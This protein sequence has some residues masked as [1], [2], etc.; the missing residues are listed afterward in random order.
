ML[1][2]GYIP[3]SLAKNNLI[4]SSGLIS[5]P[6]M[7]GETPTLIA[8][9][10]FQSMTTRADNCKLAT[11]GIVQLAVLQRGQVSWASF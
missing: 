11:S 6:F 8:L 2:I 5:R 4:S 1:F 9:A 3:L 7:G 10:R